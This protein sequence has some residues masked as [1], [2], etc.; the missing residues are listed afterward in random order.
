MIRIS[1]I[2]QKGNYTQNFP[3]KKKIN[4]TTFQPKEKDYVSMKREL[5]H[6]I[7]IVVIFI[8]IK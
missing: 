6:L 1:E 7:D 5:E 8:R 3:I 2:S 4:T